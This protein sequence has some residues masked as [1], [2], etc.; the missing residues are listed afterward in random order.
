MK[1]LTPGATAAGAVS[2]STGLPG[3]P[4]TLVWMATVK[5]GARR[6]PTFVRSWTPVSVYPAALLPVVN[7]CAAPWS[8]SFKCATAPPGL[9]LTLL[10]STSPSAV[11]SMVKVSVAKS[12]SLSVALYV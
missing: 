11:T 9:L 7:A 12:S 3:A 10:T 1:A 5:T 6:V 4:F 8:F 2:V